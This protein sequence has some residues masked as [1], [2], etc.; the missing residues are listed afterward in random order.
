MQDGRHDDDV[1]AVRFSRLVPVAL[2]DD[3]GSVVSVTVHGP[4]SDQVKGSSLIHQSV[5]SF[6]Q[7]TTELKLRYLWSIF[8]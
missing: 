1:G 7:L 3:P 4:A 5:L 2:A 6:S 8:P